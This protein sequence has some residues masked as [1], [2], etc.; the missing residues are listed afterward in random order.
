M[1]FWQIGPL[2]LWINHLAHQWRLSW[3]HSSDWLDPR[4]RAIPG[5]GAEAIP[6]HA[7]QIHCAFN[8]TREA[9]LFSPALADRPIVT[10]L[11]MPLFVLPGENVTLYVISPLWMRVDLAEPSKRLH[12]IPIFRLSDTWFGPMSSAGS[13]CY[14]SSAAAFLELREVPLR[15]HCAITAITIRNTG[16]TSLRLDRVSVPL[17]QLSLFYSPR[18]GFWTD[19]ITMDRGEGDEMATLKLDR[20][21]PADAAPT[22]FVTG[23]RQTTGGTGTVFRAFGALFRE[24]T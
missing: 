19:A 21:P 23:P 8:E 18:S 17:P 16:T 4:V 15:L 3:V 7:T 14:A 12:E 24:R 5:A 1:D 22:Q 9:L 20:Q 10:R 11:Q 2:N 6:P 13:L